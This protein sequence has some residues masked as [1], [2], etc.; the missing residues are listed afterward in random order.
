MSPVVEKIRKLL[1]IAERSESEH[2]RDAA[3]RQVYRLLN[4]HSPDLNAAMRRQW[5]GFEPGAAGRAI[6]VDPEGI[7]DGR[8]IRIRTPIRDAS[9]PVGQLN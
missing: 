5:P 1:A 2:E 8:D 9:R 4:K 6:P 3:M 7:S